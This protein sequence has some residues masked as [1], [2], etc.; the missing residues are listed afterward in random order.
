MRKLRTNNEDLIKLIT[1]AVTTMGM[2][3]RISLDIT[4]LLKLPAPKKEDK[5]VIFITSDAE[6]KMKALVQNIDKEIAWH[7]T[8]TYDANTNVYTIND[9]LVYPQLV[10]GATVTSDDEL[11]PT[12]LNELDDDTFN[13]IRMQGHSHV[14]MGVSPSSTDTEFYD[15]L[16]QHISDYYIF[17]ILNKSN[18]IYVNLYDIKNN[19]LY[20]NDD[21]IIETEGLDFN[22]WAEEQI[23]EYIGVHHIT[24]Y[25]GNS[26]GVTNANTK[27][28]KAT[29]KKHKH[30]KKVKIE[31]YPDPPVYNWWQNQYGRY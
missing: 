7:G 10:T 17:I 22:D 29:G 31:Q 20:E 21:L 15:K 8:V 2:S 18:K 30:G 5:P 24:L 13:S 26:V 19:V 4:D 6:K 1:D 16:T 25:T 9:I 14:N 23:A 11:Y 3:K 27:D 28:T 12:W